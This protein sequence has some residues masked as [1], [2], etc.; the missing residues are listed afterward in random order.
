MDLVDVDPRDERCFAAWFAV[1]DAVE[2]HLRPGEVG[3][4]LEEERYAALE[5]QRPQADDA[6]E[7]FAVRDGNRV[8][9]AARL[10]MPQL[11][12]RHAAEVL[13]E[14]LPEERRRGVGRLL[15]AELD[16]RARAH[17][18]DTLMAYAD[19]SPV[20]E[21][22]T[23]V[24]SAAAALGWEVAQV[25]VRRDLD[26]P[27]D[28][29]RCAELAAAC[30]PYAA[31]YDLGTWWDHTPD[32]LVEDRARLDTDFSEDAPKDQLD[33]RQEVWDGARVRR[34]EA[35]S[36]GMGHTFLAAGAVHRPSGRLV[37]YTEV[38]LPRSQPRRAYQWGTMVL[39]DHRGLR[40]GLLLKLRALQELAAASP[41]TQYVSTWNAQENG[42]MIAVNEAL[43][44]R[45]NGRV[46]A[47]QRKL[48]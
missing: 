26:L 6:H 30:R 2:Q 10:V 39:G 23:V 35:R 16:R 9:G 47:F 29:V 37:G 7:L 41:Q 34:D 45:T 36:R 3:R 24:R 1:L 8:V 18:R 28:P 13:L 32:E 5:G 11:D 44:A 27:L 14:V 48:V 4:L 15:A 38:G 21:A 20:G 42:P 12:N 17:G 33:W 43:G 31:D 19:E 25:D 40:L 22:G 46:L